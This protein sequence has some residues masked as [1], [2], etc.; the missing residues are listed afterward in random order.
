M[1]ISEQMIAVVPT[2]TPATIPVD[3]PTVAMVASML[4]HAIPGVEEVYVVVAPMHIDEAPLIGAGAG[5]TLISFVTVQ[6]EPRE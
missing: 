4:Y 1:V 6:P 5:F 2:P 3:A